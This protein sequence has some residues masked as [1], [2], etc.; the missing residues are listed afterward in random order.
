M[1]RE[2]ETYAEVARQMNRKESSVKA[3]YVL[4]LSKRP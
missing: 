2:G 4:T 1:V 3:R